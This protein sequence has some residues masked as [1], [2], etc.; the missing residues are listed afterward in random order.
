MT[1]HRWPAGAAVFT[2]SM[3]PDSIYEAVGFHRRGLKVIWHSKWYLE[4]CWIS[5]KFLVPLTPTARA[6][7]KIA[8][9]GSR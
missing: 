2:D 4:R 8:K 7:I 5:L 3:Y 1:R 6:M 9:Q